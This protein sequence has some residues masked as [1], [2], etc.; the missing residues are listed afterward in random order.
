MR[1]QRSILTDLRQWSKRSNRKPLILR[2]ARQVGKT[3][4]VQLFAQE[5]D[6]FISLNLELPEDQEYFTRFDRLEATVA[7][8]FF[9]HNI[10]KSAERVLLFIDEIQ[11]EPRAVAQLRYFYEKF[12]ELYVIAAGSLL[13]TLL[14]PKNVFPVGRVEYLAMRPVSFAE[15]LEAIQ[16][17]TAVELLHEKPLPPFTQPKM[18]EL[19]HRYALIGGMPEVVQ[20][21]AEEQDLVQL[22][23]IYNTLLTAYQDDVQKYAANQLRVDILRH[24]I[25]HVFLQAGSRIKFQGFGHSNYSSREIGEALRTLEKAML[26]HLVYPTTETELPGLP[27]HRKSPYLQAL[28]T[29]LL[30]FYSGLQ[31]SLIGIK[32]LH[33]AYRGRIIQHWVGQ[34]MLST[35]IYPTDRLLFWVRE[36]RQSDAEVDFILPVEGLLVP[37]EVKSGPTGKLRSLHQFMDRCD[38]SFAVRLYAGELLLQKATTPKG[39]TFHLL[40]LPYFLGEQLEAY[41][42]WMRAK[43]G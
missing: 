17:T 27:N 30:N 39:K 9:R 31:E 36:K 18:L 2:G 8:L 40:N 16:E 42:R 15:F 1:F 7:A 25:Q 23:P 10:P 41:V 24:C 3:T 11:T 34:Q 35:M 19:F 29:G 21:Y 33:E 43:V 22:K 37:I 5:F 28:D 32:D 12:P 20:R 13:E 6:H 38:H 4:A 14:E 26:L